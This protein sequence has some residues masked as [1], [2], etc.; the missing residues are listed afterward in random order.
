VPVV[1]AAPV[2]VAEL[3]TVDAV[4][5][6]EDAGAPGEVPDPGTVDQVNPLGSFGSAVKV[7]CAFQSSANLPWVFAQAMPVSHVPVV[8]S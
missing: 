8:P 5:P 7:T 3:A 6:V 1:L 4:P 2:P